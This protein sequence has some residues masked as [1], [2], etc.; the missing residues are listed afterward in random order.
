MNYCNYSKG[1]GGQEIKNEEQAEEKIEQ[2]NNSP[3]KDDFV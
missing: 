3:K 2:L 1:T